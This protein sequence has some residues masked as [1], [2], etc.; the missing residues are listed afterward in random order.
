MG[1]AIH[2]H[3]GP[4]AAFP[5]AS[6]DRPGQARGDP[7]ENDHV[8]LLAVLAVLRPGALWQQSMQVRKTK[9][10]GPAAQPGSRAMPPLYALQ[11]CGHRASRRPR[12]QHKPH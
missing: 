9:I 1:P 12:R 10:P 6:R 7:A 5:C 2:R 11:T 3:H 8:Q 4:R